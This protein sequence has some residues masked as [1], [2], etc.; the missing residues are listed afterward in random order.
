M[1][2][3][4]IKDN[5]FWVGAVDWDRRLFDALIPLPDGTS[6]NAYLIQGSEKTALL[7]TVDPSMLTVFESHLKDIKNIDFIISHHSEQDHAGALPY[8]LEKYKNAKVIATPKGK[9]MLIDH[10]H[11]Q[12][13]RIVTV[14][15]GE[16]LSLGNK[17]LEFIHAPWVHWPE[18]M[19]TYIREDKIIFTCDLFGSHL[20]TSDI[21]Y[22]DYWHVCDEAKRYYAEVMMPFR[23][24]IQKHLEK[25]KKYQIDMI[26]PSHGPVHR[27]PECIVRSHQEWVSDKVSNTVVVPYVTM[28]GSTQLMV[29]RLTEVLSE[30]GIKVEKFNLAVADTG[31]FAM[32]LVDA[33]TLV[34]GSPTVLTGAHPLVVSAAFLAN[35]LKPKLKFASIIGSYGWG[36]RMVEQIKGLLPNLKIEML[37]PVVIKG[38]PKDEDYKALDRLANEIVSRHKTAI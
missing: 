28:H 19:F 14:N 16:T 34:I 21:F 13:D 20:A 17:T 4:K 6:Y 8:V 24:T 5:M 36:G 33:A 23:T 38:L 22:N 32:S 12:E 10:L 25:L 30:N 18:T 3:K 27:D 15:D 11:I 1:K 37:E 2:P 29:E 9:P 7:D 35:A 31:K 26:A